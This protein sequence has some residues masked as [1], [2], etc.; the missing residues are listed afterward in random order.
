MKYS[1]LTNQKS[2]A[3]RARMGAGAARSLSQLLASTLH[4]PGPH[5]WTWGG[6]DFCSPDLHLLPHQ[7]QG[8]GCLCKA[9]SGWRQ[10][11]V[12]SKGSSQGHGVGRKILQVRDLDPFKTRN[13]HNYCNCW[14]KATTKKKRQKRCYIFQKPVKCCSGSFSPPPLPQ[15]ALGWIQVLERKLETLKRKEAFLPLIFL[16]IEKIEI[17]AEMFMWFSSYE[18]K[19][20][21][22]H[23]FPLANRYFRISCISQ[24]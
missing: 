6:Q 5:S 23:F 13:P 15:L 22:F 21:G 17:L 8:R 12:Y 16:G 14:R 3:G 11:S 9:G 24:L 10:L 18:L 2:C 7:L 19:E 1:D 20:K 4:L